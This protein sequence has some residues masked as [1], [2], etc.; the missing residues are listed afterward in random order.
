LVTKIGTKPKLI[1]GLIYRTRLKTGLGSQ[2]LQNKN[3]TRT[4]FLVFQNENQDF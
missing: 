3:Q 1:Y 2:I 4:G